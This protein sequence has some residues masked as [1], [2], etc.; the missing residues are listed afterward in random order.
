MDF[1][2]LSPIDDRLLAHNQILPNQVLGTN[3][4]IHTQKDGVPELTDV[5]VAMVSLEPRLVKG[6]PLHLRFRE[7]FYQLFTGN[8]DFICADLGVL[9]SGDHP[10]DT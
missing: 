6:E 3:L 1:D 9:P 10:N 8:W 2:F 7:Q 5:S 4:R